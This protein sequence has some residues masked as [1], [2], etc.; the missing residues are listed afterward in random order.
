MLKHFNEIFKE[1]RTRRK[2]LGRK[3]A[4]VYSVLKG[5]ISEVDKEWLPVE[6]RKTGKKMRTIFML[7]ESEHAKYDH[8]MQA[9]K[10][11]FF[12]IHDIL[13]CAKKEELLY[14]GALHWKMNQLL[15]EVLEVFED[16]ESLCVKGEVGKR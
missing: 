13:C 16:T 8:L 3:Y 4:G 14:N 6:V 7:F 1:N 15:D 9:Y 2:L 10:E 5:F 12:V 11:T